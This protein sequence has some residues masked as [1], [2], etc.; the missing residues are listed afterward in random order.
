VAKAYVA[1]GDVVSA[2]FD[3]DEKIIRARKLHGE[4]N[5]RGSRT[6]GY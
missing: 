4:D 1:A 6:A 3:R 5:I 2:A